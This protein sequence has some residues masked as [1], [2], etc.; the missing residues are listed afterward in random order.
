[1][2]VLSELHREAGGLVVVVDV[3][4]RLVVGGGLRDHG[5]EVPECQQHGLSV[6]VHGV[7]FGLEGEALP[8]LSRVEDDAFGDAGVVVVVGPALVGLV[9]LD[10]HLAFGV[11]AQYDLD[12]DLVLLDIGGGGVVALLHGVGALFEADGYCGV[13][14]VLDRDGGRAVVADRHE[15]G[16]GGGVESQQDGLVIVVQGVVAGHEVEALHRIAAVEDQLVGDAGVV[17]IGGPVLSR[18]GEGDGHPPLRVCVQ[19]HLDGD[20]VLPDAGGRGVVGL[21]HGVFGLF[22]AD[23]DG[24]GLVVGHGHVDRVGVYALIVCVVGL[25]GVGDAAGVV[26]GVGVVGGPDGYFL[27]GVPVLR[28]E[29]QLGLVHA[30]VGA[31]GRGD[32]D[33]HVG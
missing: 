7:V 20:P 31:A 12:I 9:Y 18:L 5:G 11:G 29:R 1:M 23:D 27:L 19:D 10:G 32:G 17:F 22:V 8:G 4:F 21:R 30:D 15:V 33:A 2:A 3:D 14:V 28:G 13:V 16:Q 6:V 24:D 26:G 25:D